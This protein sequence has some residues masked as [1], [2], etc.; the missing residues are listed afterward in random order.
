MDLQTNPETTTVDTA[1]ITFQLKEK[2]SE[3]SE[4]LLAR[5]PAMPTLLH[6]IHKTLR[7]YPEQVTLLEPDE[8]AKIVEGLKVQTNTQFAVTAVKSGGKGTKSLASKINA[9]GADA[10]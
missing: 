7:Q 10:F 5:H 2:V 9:L 6:A 1:A 3:L 8:I 4:K